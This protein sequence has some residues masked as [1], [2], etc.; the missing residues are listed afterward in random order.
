MGMQLTLVSCSDATG[1]RCLADPALAVQLIAPGDA[2]AF[3]EARAQLRAARPAWRNALSLLARLR[4]APLLVLKRGERVS[5]TL[6][7]SWHGL[8]FLLTGSAWEGTPPANF[9]L[10]G[11]QE[12]QRLQVGA[13]PARWLDATT[14]AA[15]QQTFEAISDA[16]LRA[17]FSPVAMTDAQIYPEIW[18]REPVQQNLDFLLAHATRLRKFLGNAAQAKL[19]CVLYLNS[20]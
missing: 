6:G 7:E 1:R 2:E 8:H 20:C 12:L 16:A 11:G 13:G 5:L 15:A 18:S 4:A 14:L 3:E 19:G 9:L 10:H 17:R